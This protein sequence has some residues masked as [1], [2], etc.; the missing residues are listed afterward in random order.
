MRHHILVVTSALG[1]FAG[2]FAAPSFAVDE[3]AATALLKQ[4]KCLTCHA[5]E[6]K[7]DGPAFKEVA[8]KYKDHP[9]AEAK[10]IKHVSVPSKV[11]IDGE[12]EDHGAVK[13][14]DAAKIK[15]LV[16]WILSL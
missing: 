14:R 4:S 16:D 13:T 7:K 6:T 3:A 8:A 12:M 1:I 15:N 2:I 9:E 10:L 5:I 11:E